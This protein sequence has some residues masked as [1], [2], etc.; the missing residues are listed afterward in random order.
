MAGALRTPSRAIDGAAGPRAAPLRLRAL[1]DTRYMAVAAVNG[2][3]VLHI[4]L[5]G[6][7]VPLWVTL[8]TSAPR[9]L[10]G[11]LLVINTVLAVVFQVR[12][13]RGAESLDGGVRAMR[14]AGVAL[15]ACCAVFALTAGV[16]SAGLATGLLVLGL[17]LLTAG[18]LWQ[19]AG[20][21]GLSFAL[22]PMTSRTEYLAGFGLGNSAQFVLG[23]AL[24][25]IGVIENGAVGWLALAGCFLVATAL[26]GPLVRRAV[27]RP[28]LDCEPA[29]I[30]SGS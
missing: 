4:A 26:V 20:G 5:L 9:A 16:R 22:A 1:R 2:V 15:A 25:T 3:I 27:G 21:W 19:S 7:A 28:Q 29:L 17:V 18:E 12:A 8:H 10:V 11:V 14:Y 13:S 6:T 30:N 23:P 24:V